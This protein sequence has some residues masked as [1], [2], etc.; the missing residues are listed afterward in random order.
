MIST[1]L[2][3]DILTANKQCRAYGQK[4]PK[5]DAR[6]VIKTTTLTFFIHARNCQLI[7]NKQMRLQEIA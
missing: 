7:V 1:A 6:D 2:N 3:T 5:S 4:A